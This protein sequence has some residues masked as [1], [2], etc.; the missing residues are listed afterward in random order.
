MGAHWKIQLLGGGVG[1]S[2]KTNIVRGDCQKKGG[3]GKKG[4]VFRKGWYPNAHH[5]MCI[6]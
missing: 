3:L 4:G 2:W 5:A 1:G 6:A